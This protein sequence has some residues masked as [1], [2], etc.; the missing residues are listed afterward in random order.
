[1]EGAKGERRFVLVSV[2]AIACKGARKR[3]SGVL[4]NMLVL[5]KLPMVSASGAMVFGSLADGRTAFDP[6]CD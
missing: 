1:M 3:D 6:H 5:K 2:S 4:S